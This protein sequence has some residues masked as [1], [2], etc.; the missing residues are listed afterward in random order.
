MTLGYRQ[1]IV[2]P[3][4]LQISQSAGE[5]MVYLDFHLIEFWNDKGT[6]Y[7]GTVLG[8]GG[9]VGR[10]FEKK[11]RRILDFSFAYPLLALHT[12]MQQEP[13]ATCFTAAVMSTSKCVWPDLCKSGLKALSFSLSFL[14]HPFPWPREQPINDVYTTVPISGTGALFGAH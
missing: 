11:K 13:I 1:T 5:D 10:D 7:N 14:F 9:R 3:R 12:T 6:D 2:P 4:F 8:F